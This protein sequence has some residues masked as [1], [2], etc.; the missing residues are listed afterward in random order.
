MRIGSKSIE[1]LLSV[2]E[3][4]DESIESDDIGIDK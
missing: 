3:D 4:D 2:D 1:P